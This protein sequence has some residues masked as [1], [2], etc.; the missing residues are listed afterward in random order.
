[1][2]ILACLAIGTVNTGIVFVVHDID[3]SIKFL[4]LVLTWD[5]SSGL[6]STEDEW[7]TRVGDEEDRE[8]MD[9]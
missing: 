6:S 2:A 9:K 4:F 1:M 7:A 5:W 8:A 3:I